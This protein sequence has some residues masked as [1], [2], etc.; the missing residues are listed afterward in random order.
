[1]LTKK[2][3]LTRLV[4]FNNKKGLDTLS[5]VDTI[6]WGLCAY[7]G[8]GRKYRKKRY[9]SFNFRFKFILYNLSYNIHVLKLIVGVVFL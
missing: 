1:M 9:Y 2:N 5:R 8:H 4:F 7:L 6:D 3:V